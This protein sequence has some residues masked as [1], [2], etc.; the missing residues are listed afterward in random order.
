M[1]I[2]GSR[3]IDIAAS[4]GLV[5]GLIADVTRMPEWSPHVVASSW[6]PPATGPVPGSRFTTTL[7][8][9]IVRRWTNT[10]TVTTSTPTDTFAFNVGD[11][12]ED[13]NTRW[14]YTCQAITAGTR[15]TERWEMVSEP[16]IVLVF[17]RLIRQDRR[18]A[19]GVEQTLARLKAAAEELVDRT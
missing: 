16:R 13:P 3:T 14:S 11:D 17:Y 12:P 19:I 8:L 5:W 4:P 7:R 1:I 18:L 9:P 2:A 15:V 6:L 10:S